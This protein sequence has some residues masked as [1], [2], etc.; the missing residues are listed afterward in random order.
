MWHSLLNFRIG[1]I[2]E[3]VGLTIIADMR[4]LVVSLPHHANHLDKLAI[5]RLD[6]VKCLLI[7]HEV[8]VWLR[9]VL[10]VNLD[11]FDV[12]GR[13][14][15][16]VPVKILGW[17]RATLAHG[18]CTCDLRRLP[19]RSVLPL[20]IELLAFVEVEGLH[21]RFLASHVSHELF[22]N[23]FVLLLLVFLEHHSFK[24]LLFLRW[25]LVD[26]VVLAF[27]LEAGLRRT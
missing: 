15:I 2:V 7:E 23:H 22:A 19:R 11:E 8:R 16:L 4:Y 6:D 9:L 21:E 10:L 5:V 18:V 14:L 25:P 13:V 3:E 20:T 26:V 1:L 17:R 24:V 12:R 27:R